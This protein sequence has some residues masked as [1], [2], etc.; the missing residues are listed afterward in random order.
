M[1]CRSGG[2]SIEGE[3][4][5]DACATKIRRGGQFRQGVRG[6]YDP[7]DIFGLFGNAI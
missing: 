4:A 5:L 2:G 7:G 1:D 6:G 3:N